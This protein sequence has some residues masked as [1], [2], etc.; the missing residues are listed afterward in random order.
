ML[1]KPFHQI[2]YNLRFM[3]FGVPERGKALAIDVREG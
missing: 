1:T 2:M 3:E